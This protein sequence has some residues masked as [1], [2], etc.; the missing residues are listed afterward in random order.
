MI[1]LLVSTP[2][3]KD[4]LGFQLA[5]VKD[6]ALVAEKESLQQLV[7]VRFHKH[8]VH[9]SILG[10]KL[11]QLDRTGRTNLWHICVHVLLEVHSEELKDEIELGFLHQHILQ[12]DN[13]WMLQFFQ[14]GDLADCC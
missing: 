8:W 2:I 6:P 9:L 13:I 7:G 11:D 12:G 10:G 3:Y 1:K 4:S 5:P 14:Q